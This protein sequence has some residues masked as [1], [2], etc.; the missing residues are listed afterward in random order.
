[1]GA[2]SSR[3]LNPSRCSPSPAARSGERNGRGEAFAHYIGTAYAA[4]AVASRC[5][6]TPVPL[7]LA[8]CVSPY[9]LA[10]VAEGRLRALTAPARQPPLAGRAAA[11]A[12]G[13][14]LPWS[15][16]RPGSV[17]AAPRSRAGRA[18]LRARASVWMIGSTFARY[19]ANAA[20]ESRRGG[21][22]SARMARS[23]P[24]QMALPRAMTSCLVAVCPPQPRRR[25]KAGGGDRRARGRRRAHVRPGPHDQVG[26]QPGPAGLMRGAE[27]GAGVAVEVLVKRDEVVPGRVVRGAAGSRR[28]RG[29]GRRRPCG[30]WR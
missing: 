12:C 4:F 23:A 17:R 6:D 30:R 15:P 27:A 3:R 19:S 1:M 22:G 8:H 10:S 29:G 13:T 14:A 11:S 26:H 7:A 25:R 21:R 28:A 5:H 20:V 16:W 24:M 9:W 18:A 2:A